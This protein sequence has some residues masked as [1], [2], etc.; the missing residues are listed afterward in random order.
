[1][2]D[3]DLFKV[4]VAPEYAEMS[5]SDLDVFATEAELEISQKAFGKFYPRCV[6]LI[7]AHLINLSK[8]SANGSS[9]SPGELKKVKVGDLEREYAVS[10]ADAKTNGSY[11][12]TIYGKEFVRLRKKV[13]MGPKFVS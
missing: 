10:A 5:N 13:L 9:S 7:T 6:A 3:Y 2:L 12:L 11:S 4:V 8:R 1:M